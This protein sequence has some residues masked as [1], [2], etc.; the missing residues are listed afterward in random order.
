VRR[1]RRPRARR[2]SAT[3]FCDACTTVTHCDTSYR[4]AAIRDNAETR[5]L[6]H[7]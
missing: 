3:C 2:H 5:A 1:L 7:R 6:L 4:I